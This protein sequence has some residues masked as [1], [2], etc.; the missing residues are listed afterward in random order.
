MGSRTMRG[1]PLGNESDHGQE[2]QA[3]PLAFLQDLLRRVLE[4]DEQLAGLKRTLMEHI[5]AIRAGANPQIRAQLDEDIRRIGGGEVL[6]GESLTA[7]EYLERHTQH[8]G[9]A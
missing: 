1:R 2:E 5:G 9:I 4:M 6:E 8:R 3:D 7:A